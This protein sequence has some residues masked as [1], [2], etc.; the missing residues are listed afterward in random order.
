MSINSPSPLP[1]AN[2][3][4][5]IKMKYPPFKAFCAANAAVTPT[6][7][8]SPTCGG[9]EK[10]RK[11]GYAGHDPHNPVSGIIS[12]PLS[13]GEGAEGPCLAACLTVRQV[14]KRQAMVT[15]FSQPKV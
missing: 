4:K 2:S 9:G 5:I 10:D 3:G 12:P 7:D 15:F 1:I 14:M 8:P 11:L 13:S 6:P